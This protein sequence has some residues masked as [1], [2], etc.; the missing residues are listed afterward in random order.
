V[1]NMK[2]YYYIPSRADNCQCGVSVGEI[3]WR[4]GAQPRIATHVVNNV[5]PS[6]LVP[7][8]LS[9]DSL[10]RQDD[11]STVGARLRAGPLQYVKR[12]A[13]ERGLYRVFGSASASTAKPAS[14][15]LTRY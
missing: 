6:E 12:A 13:T 4:F 10:N 8:H 2:I 3:W 7:C 15:N 1:P 5:A 11:A 9:I 14:R